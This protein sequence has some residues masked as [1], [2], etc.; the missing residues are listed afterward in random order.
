MK[1][2][3]TTGKNWILRVS[4]LLLAAIFVVSL[5]GCGG[6]DEV[7]DEA[8]FY[9]DR[10]ATVRIVMEEEDWD[11]TQANSSAE[12]YVKAD[13]WFDDE[14]VPDVAVRPKGNSSLMS[15]AQ[16]GS[17]RMSLKVDFNF[18]NSARTLYGLKKANFNN[19]FSDPTLIREV[20]SYELF[21][22]MGMPTPRTS[23]VDIWVND[24][25][26]GLYTMVEQIDKAFLADHFNDSNG[27]LY[28]PE[29][30]A[31]DLNWTVEDLPEEALTDAG[32]DDEDINLG[33]GKL[34]DIMR[35]LGLEETE[36]EEEA[37][38]AGFPQGQQENMPFGDTPA[39]NFTRGEM[40]FGGMRREGMGFGD[41]PSFNITL[42][43]MPFGD[44][45]F[46]DMPAANI[47]QRV[48]QAGGMQPGGMM[49]MGGNLL[50]QM[51]LKTNENKED[52]S[53]LFKLLDVLNKEP[54]ETFREEIEKV[55][56]VDQVLR[57]IAVST[58]LV[59]LD[60][61][62][63]MGHNYYLYEVDGKFTII[64][65]DLNMSFG[66]FNSGLDRE[67]IINFLIDEPT[68]GA[69][70]DRPLVARL[71]A[72]P[73]YLDTYHGYLIELIDGPFSCEVMETRIDE[74]ADMMRPYVEADTLKF[75][76]TAEFEKGLSDDVAITT[77]MSGM[78]LN[79]GLK[80]FVAERGE[81]IRKQLAGELLSTN[82][83]QGNGGS[84]MMIG[85]RN[86]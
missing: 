6:Q 28:K 56:D 37:A 3:K 81:S 74:L 2:A 30:Q 35:A 46:G 42:E 83:G 24:T 19:G 25:H 18:F 31:S 34:T 45:A 43:E 67:G 75:Y 80:A 61:Y 76:T 29:T 50:E 72:V 59:H 12:E 4:G 55:L 21:E 62:T 63:G 54:D 51:G 84:S 49:G 23:F 71:L 40:R 58:V 14:L 65:W 27:N 69:V 22:Q 13:F 38:V 77:R 26:L 44:I 78:G 7:A 1:K 86:R 11:Y 36:E 20:L 32:E 16:S 66:N 60:N 9:T 39:G 48:V 85:F 73:E 82:G 41:M 5:A 70:A 17:A 79:I 8:P 68:A 33:G 53:A 10:V 52:Y 64:P 15:V 57:F 47:T